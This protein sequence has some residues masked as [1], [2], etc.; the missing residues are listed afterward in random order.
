M[1]ENKNLYHW[2]GVVLCLL[3]MMLS[4][5]ASGA[6]TQNLHDFLQDEGYDTT[7]AQVMQSVHEVGESAEAL[8][9]E[10]TV[11]GLLYDGETLLMGWRTENKTPDELALVQYIEVTAGGQVLDADADHPLSSW[12]PHY[13][14]RNVHDDPNNN[15]MGRFIIE[16]ARRYGLAGEVA[17]VAKFA[18]QRP[19][20]PLALYDP[21]GLTRDVEDAAM[22]DNKAMLD[23]LA[24]QGIPIVESM[25]E[26]KALMAQ[27]TVLVAY[28]GDPLY[29]S[30]GEF[31][32]S[33]IGDLAADDC[34]QEAFEIAFT[35][36]LG[37]QKPP[38]TEM[39]FVRDVLAPIAKETDADTWSRNRVSEILGLAWEQGIELPYQDAM[40]LMDDEETVYKET[41]IRLFLKQAWGLYQASWSIEDQ[42][43]CNAL[44]LELGLVEVRS[45]LLPE[46][47]D[48]SVDK[49][50]AIAQACIFS[51]YD[52]DAPLSDADVYRQLMT[53]RP[54]GADR[55]WW[56]AYEA[57]DLAHDGYT[58]TMT[59]GGDVLKH[60][61]TKGI[62]DAENPPEP[63]AIMDRFLYVYGEQSQWD[64]QLWIDLSDMLRKAEG[65]MPLAMACYAQQAYALPND[66]ALTKED[67]IRTA[68]GALLVGDIKPW[69]ATA[70]YL[71]DGD[72][73]IWKV[74][75]PRTGL[76]AY[77]VEMDAYTGEVRDL[78]GTEEATPLHEGFVLRS[79]WEAQG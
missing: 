32:S 76:G 48:V 78:R 63:I 53:L 20:K 7:D 64:M 47:D 13:M 45:Y 49:A 29:L 11:E 21:D 68:L 77:Q 73:A 33:S 61:I 3:C 26:A 36:D 51:E 28:G 56:V 43:W 72:V 15:L 24:S 66:A 17:F 52:A 41:L 59:S 44:M 70:V 18:V 50:I 40:Q 67:A 25:E 60:S 58:V 1:H 23:A 16:H 6:A 46:G 35:V 22:L 9:V 31:V 2:V 55:I 74:A 5:A 19:I 27:G 71:M 69:N 4:T 39:E 79:V 57:R 54:D 10:I 14:S 38:I 42:A 37:E 75:V 30:D 65:H 12:I 62:M 8:G 34:E